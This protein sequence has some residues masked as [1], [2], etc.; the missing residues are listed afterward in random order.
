MQSSACTRN[1]KNIYIY[2]YMYICG[3]PYNVLTDDLD[4]FPCEFDGLDAFHR[5]FY[6]GTPMSAPYWKVCANVRLH[7][8]PALFEVYNLPMG[9]WSPLWDSLEARL[10]HF[11]FLFF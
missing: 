9:L 8:F 1:K 5:N 10:S 7:M 4:V 11:V 3:R 2:I 6:H